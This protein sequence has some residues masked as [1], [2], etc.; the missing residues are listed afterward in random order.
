MTGAQPDA[1]MMSRLQSLS[2]MLA[3]KPLAARY[4]QT[5]ATFTIMMNDV[6]KIIGEA[7]GL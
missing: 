2:A 3:T 1:D 6:F 7:V 5:Q 4:L